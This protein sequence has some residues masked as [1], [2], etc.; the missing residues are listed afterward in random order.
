MLVEVAKTV[1]ASSG[2]PSTSCKRHRC[3][4]AYVSL[5]LTT[6]PVCP[7]SLGAPW[8]HLFRDTNLMAT[9]VPLPIAT[10]S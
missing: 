6:V 4:L 10:C 7:R 1:S 5:L 9:V 8:R 2:T 3:A